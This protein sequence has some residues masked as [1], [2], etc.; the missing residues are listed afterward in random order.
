MRTFVV[1]LLLSM[2]G[3]AAELEIRVTDEANRPIWTRLEVRGAE[4]KMYQPP[5]AL[6]DTRGCVGLVS[7]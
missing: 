7:D 2:A 4:G 1:A 5:S 3:I 6:R